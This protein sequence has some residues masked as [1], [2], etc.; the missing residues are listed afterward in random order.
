[1]DLT[2]LK[3]RIRVY[4]YEGED[5]TFRASQYTSTLE[6]KYMMKSFEFDVERCDEFKDVDIGDFI[7]T[8]SKNFGFIKI[9]EV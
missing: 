3:H 2:I 7:Y 8:Y 1:M 6:L 5:S 9:S 4:A